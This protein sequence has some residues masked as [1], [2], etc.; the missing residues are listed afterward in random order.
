MILLKKIKGKISAIINAVTFSP[1]K[2]W[3]DR[4]KKYGELAVL[5]LGHGKEGLNKIKE[6]QLQT[7]FPVLKDQLRGNENTLLDFGCG[8][9]R[10]SVELAN[11]IGGNVTAVDP[12]DH[13]L[14]L[15]P[16]ADNINYKKIVDNKIPAADSSFDVIWICL[17]L[18]GITSNHN[19]K[20]AVDEI[21]R[22][23]RPNALLL[24]IENT[25]NKKN[26][27]SWKYRSKDTY[28]SLFKKFDLKNLI[29]YDDLGE[30]NS[31]FA[32]RK[33]KG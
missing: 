22:V 27:L 29:D 26:I 17:V 24:L 23:A 31:I 20:L 6:I 18:G 2:Y 30:R 12:I 3:E 33:F 4:A 14:Q 10:F 32:G 16:K 28:I 13:L 19:L 11:L 8:S 21:N 1:I 15:A 5:N 7:I 25:S 9:G